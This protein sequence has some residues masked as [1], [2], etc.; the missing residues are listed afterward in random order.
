MHIGI[1]QFMLHPDLQSG[2]GP[3]VEAAEALAA[4]GFFH[5]LEIA[6]INDPSERAAMRRLAESAHLTLGYGAHPLILSG[7]LNLA[8]TDADA[9]AKTLF[10]RSRA[11]STRRPNS[12]SRW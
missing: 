2:D 5:A 3:A 7:G 8:S 12:A 1:V 6:H 11:P 4:D 10:P 9:H